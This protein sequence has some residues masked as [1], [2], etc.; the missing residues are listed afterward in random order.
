MCIKQPCADVPLRWYFMLA[1]TY[2]SAHAKCWIASDMHAAP[3]QFKWPVIALLSTPFHPR[4]LCHVSL[5]RIAVTTA[6]EG[7]F[8][9]APC[10]D[11]VDR[12]MCGIALTLLQ[13]ACEEQQASHVHART[14]D[15]MSSI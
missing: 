15:S 6:S 14:C 10:C 13:A 3:G 2:C 8:S 4:Q 9:L 5:P 7:L 1:C 12:A 11:I